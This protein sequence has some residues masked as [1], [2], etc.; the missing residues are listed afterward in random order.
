MI[1]IRPSICLNI[2]YLRN[3]ALLTQIAE[4]GQTMIWNGKEW[5]LR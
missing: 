1:K 4:F 2:S 5:D 3:S